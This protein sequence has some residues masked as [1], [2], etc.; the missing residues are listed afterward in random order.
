M[1]SNMLHASD[2]HPLPNPR[3]KNISTLLGAAMNTSHASLLSRKERK[4]ERKKTAIASQAIGR[5][6]HDVAG[7]LVRRRRRRHHIG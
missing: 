2:P 4:K 7:M 1:P 5:N 3:S 6:S